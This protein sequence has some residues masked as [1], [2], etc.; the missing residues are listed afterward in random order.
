[1]Y[2]KLKKANNK[3]W[4]YLFG[5][6]S[7]K[8]DVVIKSTW[9]SKATGKEE[10]D[11]GKGWNRYYSFNILLP[12]LNDLIFD[13]TILGEEITGFDVDPVQKFDEVDRLSNK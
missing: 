5:L 11:F 2:K 8:H 1:L 7:G 12:D 3:H 4:K 9:E 10:Y 13:D 6:L